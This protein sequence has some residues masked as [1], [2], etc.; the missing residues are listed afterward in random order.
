MTDLSHELSSELPA[1]ENLRDKPGHS[2]SAGL[3]KVLESIARSL[4]NPEDSIAIYFKNLMA[5][6][7]FQILLLKNAGSII[8][9]NFNPEKLAISFLSAKAYKQTD[10]HTEKKMIQQFSKLFLALLNYNEK[11]L[12]NF[13]YDTHVLKNLHFNSVSER[14]AKRFCDRF[15]NIKS[16]ST[17]TDAFKIAT[18]NI[19][20][21]FV[22]VSLGII[23]PEIFCLLRRNVSEKE[24]EKRTLEEFYES[25]KSNPAKSKEHSDLQSSGTVFRNQY[26]VQ[27]IKRSKITDE[28]IRAFII[29]TFRMS[30]DEILE[31]MQFDA[32]FKNITEQ[33]LK[34]GCKPEK[35]ELESI[36]N[37]AL[38]TMLGQEGFQ[39]LVIKK[40][41][42]PEWRDALALF[43]Q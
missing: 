22:L 25:L 7:V 21:E 1:A 8:K 37:K 11:L 9:L 33:L 35:D 17:I 3:E 31:A 42:T 34:L 23:N 28:K 12:Y 19:A 36:L 2:D 20:A 13:L 4:K 15:K 6:P 5:D 18:S 26:F 32:G 38:S 43:Y 29:K 16:N 41:T 39:T 10:K 40:V 30:S 27:G 24:I 14:L